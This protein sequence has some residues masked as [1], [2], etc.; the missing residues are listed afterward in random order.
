M[1][2]CHISCQFGL[3]AGPSSKT[4]DCEGK[5]II[6]LDMALK[7]SAQTWGLQS[8]SRYLFEYVKQNVYNTFNKHSELISM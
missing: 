2:F 7:R 6:R 3:T 8:N 4:F 5:L 1:L